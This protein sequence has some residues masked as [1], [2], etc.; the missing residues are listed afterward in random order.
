[1]DLW[2]FDDGRDRVHAAAVTASGGRHVHHPPHPHQDRSVRARKRRAGLEDGMRSAHDPAKGLHFGKALALPRGA[3]IHLVLGM[4]FGGRDRGLSQQ[5]RP[6]G[7][8][9]AHA[10]TE[11]G[12]GGGQALRARAIG[13]NR[14]RHAT[15][16]YVIEILHSTTFLEAHV[17]P[18]TIATLSSKNGS[19]KRTG[20]DAKIVR[21]RNSWHGSVVGMA[22]KHR[23]HR[24]GI[25]LCSVLFSHG[26]LT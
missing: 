3:R 12:E 19:N 2:G 23:L 17:W 22:R 18:R 5:R 26:V 4:G 24:G 10:R 21:K 13:P 6:Q 25:L 16:R 8:R 14:R 7:D 15:D 1:M 9:A 11:R 20:A